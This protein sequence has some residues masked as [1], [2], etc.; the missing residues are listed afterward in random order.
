MK[1]LVS[2]KTFKQKKLGLN[3]TCKIQSFL[4]IFE[5]PI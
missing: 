4:V 1:L 2:D 3:L 5:S